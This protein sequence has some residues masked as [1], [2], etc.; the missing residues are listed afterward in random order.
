MTRIGEGVF[1]VG[2][3]DWTLRDFHGYSTPHGTTYNAYLVL[4]EKK[5][6]IDTVRSS[7]LPQLLARVKEVLDPGEIDYLVSLHV[8]S[9]TTPAAWP[10]CWPSAPRPRW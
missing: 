6:L 7:H 2:A 3:I 8:E 5:A 4:D 9:R 10:R 1:W